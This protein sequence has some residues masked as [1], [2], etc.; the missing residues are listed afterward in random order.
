MRCAVVVMHRVLERQAWTHRRPR[1]LLPLDLGQRGLAV[2]HIG[3]DIRLNVRNGG[4]DGLGGVS[5]R[6]GQAGRQT[7]HASWLAVAP[8]MPGLFHTS[9]STRDE[10]VMARANC[11]RPLA[12]ILLLLTPRLGTVSGLACKQTWNRQFDGRVLLGREHAGEVLDAVVLDAVGSGDI[13][14]AGHTCTGICN[15]R[16]RPL[17]VRLDSSMRASLR[18]PSRVTLL[19]VWGQIK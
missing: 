4:C 13:Y 12:P 5:G 19:L 18:A 10:P 8:Q 2:H 6:D 3:L 15:L 7:A 1:K 17:R 9:T 16:S 11:T 14:N